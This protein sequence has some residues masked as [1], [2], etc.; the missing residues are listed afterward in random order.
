MKQGYNDRMDDSLGNRDGKESSKEQNYKDRRDEAKAMNKA[1]GKRAYQSVD[2]MDKK[3]FDDVWAK[4]KAD[5]KKAFGGK[6]ADGGK[7][8]RFDFGYV[9]PRQKTIKGAKYNIF[10]H[11]KNMTFTNEEKL[12]AT[13]KLKNK[14]FEVKSRNIAPY[15][16]KEKMW[17]LLV[18]KEYAKGGMVKNNIVKH[19]ENNQDDKIYWDAWFRGADGKE[20]EDADKGIK[21]KCELSSEEIADK[22]MSDTQAYQEWIDKYSRQY[23]KGGGVDAEQLKGYYEKVQDE[24]LDLLYDDGNMDYNEAEEL[25]YEYKDEQT[26]LIRHEFEKGSSIKTAAERVLSR[27]NWGEDDGDDWDGDYAKGGKISSNYF[28]G[29]LSFLNY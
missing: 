9:A 4:F 23:A 6:Y 19:L 8:E 24:I 29:M 10:S 3:S 22:L 13:K 26:D 16:T 7:I 15:G 21:Y 14:G 12:E 27:Y 5:T 2:T 11:P 28:S 20:L 17:Q 25:A 18:K 1:E